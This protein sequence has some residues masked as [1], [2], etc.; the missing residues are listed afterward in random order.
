MI[1][2]LKLLE[3]TRNAELVYTILVDDC[4]FTDPLWSTKLVKA[5]IALRVY[6]RSLRVGIIDKDT[7]GLPK[8]FRQPLEELS[9]D[10]HL[11]F[12][13]NCVWF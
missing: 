1:P 3:Y 11:N 2:S 12:P 8:L 13:V 4:G 10:S 5:S 7:Y 9:L 6:S